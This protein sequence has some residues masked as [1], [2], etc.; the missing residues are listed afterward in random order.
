MIYAVF[1]KELINY[2]SLKESLKSEYI[3]DISN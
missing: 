3:Y 1:F 2:P